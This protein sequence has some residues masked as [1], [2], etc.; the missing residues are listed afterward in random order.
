[1][2]FGCPE[3]RGVREYEDEEQ[4]AVRKETGGTRMCCNDVDGGDKEEFPV[5]ISR[6]IGTGIWIGIGK[7]FGEWRD[8]VEKK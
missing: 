8:R 1:M 6:R 5:T 4:E 2:C 3:R 7:G